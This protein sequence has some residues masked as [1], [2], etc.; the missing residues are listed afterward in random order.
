MNKIIIS[1]LLLSFTA[2]SAISEKAGK[3]IPKPGKECPAQGE[4]TFKDI[5]CKE[6]K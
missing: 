1:L 4:R 6:P 5:L 3:I 2:C